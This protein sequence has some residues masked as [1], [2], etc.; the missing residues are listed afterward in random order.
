MPDG[1]ISSV[2]LADGHERFCRGLARAISACSR[3][4]LTTTVRDGALAA[5][6]I[7]RD[8]PDLA[9]LDVRLPLLDGYEIATFLSAQQ[10]RPRTRVILI[11]ALLDAAAITRATRAGAIGC[12]GKDASRAEICEALLAAADGVAWAADDPVKGIV[13][14]EATSR[15]GAC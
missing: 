4:W 2:L 8:Q 7:E 1:A 10:S 3:L 9:L 13:L 11:T 5:A 14:A 15:P 6:V 12:L